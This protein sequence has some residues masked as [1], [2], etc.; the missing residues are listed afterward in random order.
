MNNSVLK[1]IS[2][3]L[4]FIIV[5]FL[6]YS[7]TYEVPFVFDDIHSIKNNTYI[8][9][10]EITTDS[11]VNVFYK[12]KSSLMRAI[13][14]VTFALNYYFHQYSL[15][16]YRIVNIIIHILSG[17]ILYFFIKTTLSI[18][19]LQSKYSNPDIIAFFS[20]IVWFVH[21]LH[22]QSVTYIVQRMTSMSAMFSVLSM[23][24]YATGRIRQQQ[25]IS[26]TFQNKTVYGP[27]ISVTS[28]Y[29]L[30]AVVVWFMA[31]FS[32]ENAAVLPFFIFL[33]EWYF[34]QDLD[35]KWIKR[36]M[37]II[38]A[39]VLLISVT[40]FIILG[41][42]PLHRLKSIADFGRNEFT[43]MERILTQPRVVIHYITLL[44]YPHPSRLNLDYDFPLSHSLI[45]PV[46]TLFSVFAIIGLI[47]LAVYSA[48]QERLLSFCI[49]WFFGNLVIESS[50]IP[51]AIIFEHRTYLPSMFI[52]LFIVFYSIIHTSLF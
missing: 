19:T 44:F 39:G 47:W 28:L 31:L 8:R 27:I 40:A 46:T 49:L 6:I 15:K 18:S 13:P 45:D 35:Q 22:T 30:G 4:L 12:K 36:N 24:L 52:C 32:K 26:T 43:F 2:I 51:L 17:I 9:I 25:H 14:K 38:F 29:F 33:Y 21:P 48:K 5:G 16:G 1:N 42:S 10:N 11:L 41:T 23:L 34:F 3:L 20:T 7:N 37:K 50:V